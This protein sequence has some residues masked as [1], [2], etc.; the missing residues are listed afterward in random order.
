MDIIWVHTEILLRTLNEYWIV[1]KSGKLIMLAS[2]NLNGAAHRL[3]REALYLSEKQYFLEEISMYFRYYCYWAL[4]LKSLF[5]KLCSI[6]IKI[7]KTRKIVNS[8]KN[9][10]FP[11]IQYSLHNLLEPSK[12]IV[13]NFS[14]LRPIF[15]LLFKLYSKHKC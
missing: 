12:A 11:F 4:Y 13:L 7:N 6:L 5:I 9:N 2:R 3:A 1:Y 15:N 10:M 14:K 8:W